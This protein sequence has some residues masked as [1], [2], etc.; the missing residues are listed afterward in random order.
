MRRACSG[1]VSMCFST[2]SSPLPVVSGSQSRVRLEPCARFQ[3]VRYYPHEVMG[4]RSREIRVPVVRGRTIREVQPALDAGSVFRSKRLLGAHSRFR[5][6]QSLRRIGFM[7]PIAYL[8]KE[9][10]GECSSRGA[11]ISVHGWFSASRRTSPLRHPISQHESEHHGPCCRC[12]TITA[13]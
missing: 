13:G 10:L 11:H 6:S 4:R 5:Q 3:S 12:P 7:V 1:R 9:R 2:R 8:Q